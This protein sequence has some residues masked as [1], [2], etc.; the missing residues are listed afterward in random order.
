MIAQTQHTIHQNRE[1]Q[2]WRDILNRLAY[3]SIFR[4][5]LTVEEIQNYLP[6]QASLDDLRV[7]LAVLVD[8]KLCFRAGQYYSTL[9]SVEINRAERLT[10]EEVAARYFQKL[11]FYARIISSFPFVRGVAISG[12]LS[13]GV[14]H[15]DGDIDYFIITAHNRLWITRLMLVLFKK[16]FLLNSHKYFCIN[17]FVSENHLD[18]PDH[19]L[20]TATEIVTLMPVYQPSVIAE[21]KHANKWTNQFYSDFSQPRMVDTVE[22]KQPQ[23]KRF[24]EYVLSNRMGD[25][26]DRASM[27]LTLFTWKRKFKQFDDEKFELTMRS[28]RNVSKHHPQDFQNQVLA[29][30]TDCMDDINARMEKVI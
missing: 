22:P 3:F 10:K 16:I 7:A 11:P 27:K 28:T 21:F 24:F 2:L 9:K 14:I 25:W 18:I 13:K 4:Y 1:T 5:P 19:N 20:F 23:L 17:Y 30:L 26:L 12:S 8:K 15:E 29:K 6:Y